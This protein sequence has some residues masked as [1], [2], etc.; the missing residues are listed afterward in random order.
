VSGF[1]RQLSNVLSLKFTSLLVRAG[2]ALRVPKRR[3]RG[4]WA[5]VLSAAGAADGSQEPERRRRGRWEP[6]ANASA[7]STHPLDH[8]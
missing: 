6:G 3:R 4:R 7:P 5:G 8:R 2:G 1:L